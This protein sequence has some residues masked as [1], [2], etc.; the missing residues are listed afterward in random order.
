[1]IPSWSPWQPL[2]GELVDFLREQGKPAMASLVERLHYS[3]VECRKAAEQNLLALYEIKAKYEPG[4]P[5]EH[6]PTWTGD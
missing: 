5:R 2:I 1:M 3:Q 6:A 4:P